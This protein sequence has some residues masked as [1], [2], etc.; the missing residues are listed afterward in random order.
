MAQGSTVTL[1]ATVTPASGSTTPTGTV[2]FYTGTTLLGSAQLSNGVAV[3]STTALPVG[4]DSLT[5]QYGGSSS[6]A[7]STSAA[8]SVTVVVPDFT[9]VASPSAITVK[10]GSTAVSK[11]TINPENG[12]SQTVT[13]TCSGLP[14]GSVCSFGTPVQNADGTSSVSL[15][16]ST[17]ATTAALDSDKRSGAPL[18]ALLPSEQ[19]AEV[20][21]FPCE[22][23][24]PVPYEVTDIVIAVPMARR[25]EV[26]IKMVCGQ[27][28]AGYIPGT[29]EFI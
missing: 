10:R 19:H 24:V 9:M 7:V 1:S 11:I 13:F 28:F 21:Q 15:S 20:K 25:A 8:A 18:L 29:H 27:V 12:F 4:T 14:S 22:I 26:I 6:F 23:S 3:L 16:I 2:N 5:A 17:A